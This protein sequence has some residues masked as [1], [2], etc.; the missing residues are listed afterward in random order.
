[1]PIIWI[2]LGGIL[3]KVQVSK[4]FFCEVFVLSYIIPIFYQCLQSLDYYCC[5]VIRPCVGD[6]S[7]RKPWVRIGASPEEPITFG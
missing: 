7:P 6:C 5:F 1:M 4:G 3:G 2:P